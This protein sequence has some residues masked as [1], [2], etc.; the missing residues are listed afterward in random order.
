MGERQRR[1]SRAFRKG[2]VLGVVAGA[3]MLIWNA[4]QPGWKTREM[5]IDAYERA[6]FALLD[7]PEKLAALRGPAEPEPAP[8]PRAA[9]APFPPAPS[10]EP[11][12][13]AEMDIVIETRPSDLAR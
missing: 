10:P 1:E 11:A 9:A 5:V 7:F 6:L 8:A 12:A 3:G 4:P 13:G 2:F